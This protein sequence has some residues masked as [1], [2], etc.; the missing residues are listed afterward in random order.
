[1]PVYLS[2]Y[3]GKGSKADPYRPRGSIDGQPWSSIDLRPDS[4]KVDGFALLSQNAIDLDPL[5]TKLSDQSGSSAKSDAISGSLKNSLDTKLAVSIGSV[6]TLEELLGDLL[7][8]ERASKWKPL[9]WSSRGIK[10]CYLGGL[11]F[12]ITGGPSNP[13]YMDPTDNFN[14]DDEDPI[15]GDWSHAGAGGTVALASNQ[16]TGTG[17]SGNRFIR[18]NADSFD[19]DQ[20]SEIECVTPGSTADFGAAARIDTGGAVTGYLAA[21]YMPEEVL[22]KLVTGTYTEIFSVD[23]TNI[24]ATDVLRIE[25][26][27][28]T[29]RWILNSTEEGS[30][31]DSSIAS[32]AAGLFMYVRD[33]V[34]DNW[35]GGNLAAPQAYFPYKH[36]RI[37]EVKYNF[38][39][40][41]K[42]LVI[43]QQVTTTPVINRPRR[44]TETKPYI[45]RISNVILPA[46]VTTVNAIISR[47]RRIIDNKLLVIRSKKVLPPAS[48]VT[49]NV[50][51]N[52][53]L[54][55]TEIKPLT[56]HTKRVYPPASVTLNNVVVNRPR[57]ITE[58]N[59][60]VVQ[61]KNVILPTAVTVSNV[62]VN[63]PRRIIE[64]KSL[65]ILSRKVLPPA[66]VT[67]NNVVVNR[68]CRIVQLPATIHQHTTKVIQTQQ[69]VNAIITRPRHIFNYFPT[70]QSRAVNIYP[71][72]SGSGPVIITKPRR[73]FITPPP[74]L[75]RTTKV[76]FTGSVTSPNVII[77][78][79]RRTM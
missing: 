73:I 8:N 62:V 23:T 39:H 22:G 13:V 2:P 37:E 53:P 19:N 49:S 27:G 14:R 34:L 28:T 45:N 70:I 74:V 20:F 69:T 71:Q 12:R 18:W 10:E 57:R 40:T 32:G 31:T 47:P 17:A 55:I 66:S 76:F 35:V 21:A 77:S 5:L 24:V 54:R 60:V 61:T 36:R 42:S 26:E 4:T 44:V 7:L 75:P 25:A 38:I 78:H 58:T 48:V 63:R 16:L 30:V 46:P 3:V 72:G 29:I 1:M 65:V 11:W 67:V 41:R 43:N 15:G 64:N 59:P 9:R 6:S 33:M 79:S 52:R 51:V 68:P 56:I 50:I